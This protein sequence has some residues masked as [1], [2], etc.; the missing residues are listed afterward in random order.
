ML[1]WIKE[2][3]GIIQA[4]LPRPVFL[5]VFGLSQSVRILL[6]LAP[7]PTAGSLRSEILDWTPWYG[8][9]IGWLALLWAGA[10]EYSLKRKE[11]FDMTSLNFFKAFLDSLIQEGHQLFH[12]SDQKDFYSKINDWQHM[13]IEGIAIGLGPEESQK[14]F[15]KIDNQYPL[16]EA[17]RDF[18]GSRSSEPLSR[19][20]QVNLEELELIRRS[21]R[22]TKVFEK[23]ELEA[24]KRANFAGGPHPQLPSK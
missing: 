10:I 15:Q 23:G 11:N 7:A 17:Y 2:R 1:H 12:H 9:V 13:V 19:S 4:I 24:L 18:L 16:T 14:Y 6:A 20:L 3:L 8:W 5:A 22:E 21:L